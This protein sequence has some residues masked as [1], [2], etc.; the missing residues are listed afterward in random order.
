MPGFLVGGALSPVGE[1]WIGSPET[2]PSGSTVLP[3]VLG[4]GA[5][6]PTAKLSRTQKP[7]HHPSGGSIA[8]PKLAFVYKP[9]T[10][11]TSAS[12]F[13]PKASRGAKPAAWSNSQSFYA[14]GLK[15]TVAPVAFANAPVFYGPRLTLRISPSACANAGQIQTAAISQGASAKL[16]P[17]RPSSAAIFTPSVVAPAT[18]SITVTLSLPGVAQRA[19]K[20]PPRQAPATWPNLPSIAAS[21]WR[22]TVVTPELARE[23]ARQ[24]LAAI[25]RT[26]RQ[27]RKR[28]ADERAGELLAE[29]ID[30][31]VAHTIVNVLARAG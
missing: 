27:R 21:P 22:L 24:R 30:D 5:T 1:A 4:N 18:T 19:P 28:K 11:G 12:L 20:P 31:E 23:R 3:A 13:A 29:L 17:H 14:A 25:K 6:F 10:L 26:E 2:P 9:V 15:R 16:A 8:L 7:A